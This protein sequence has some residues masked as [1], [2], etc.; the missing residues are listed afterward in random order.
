MPPGPADRFENTCY[1]PLRD[2]KRRVID[3]IAN[4]VYRREPKSACAS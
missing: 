3:K 1:M 2:W 4:S